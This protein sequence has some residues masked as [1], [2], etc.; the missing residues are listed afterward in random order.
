MTAFW[1]V[2]IVVQVSAFIQPSLQRRRPLMDQTS[3]CVSILKSSFLH[4]SFRFKDS[5]TT[6]KMSMLD[7][8]NDGVAAGLASNPIQPVRI[9]DLRNEPDIYFEVTQPSYRESP[10]KVKANG[11][12]HQSRLHQIKKVQRMSASPFGVYLKWDLA[13][14]PH[15]QLGQSERSDIR[16]RL[17]QSDIPLEIFEAD[18]SYIADGDIAIF[19]G[20]TPQFNKYASSAHQKIDFS[21]ILDK[22]LASTKRDGV[23]DRGNA[24]VSIGFA[25]LNQKNNCGKDVAVPQVIEATDRFYV[26]QMCHMSKLVDSLSDCLPS[27]PPIFKDDPIRCKEFAGSLPGRYGINDAALYNTLEAATFAVTCVDNGSSEQFTFGC[28]VDQ[29]NDRLDNWNVVACAFN[30]VRHQGKLYRV[31]VI[32]YS[33]S[34]IHHF[35]LRLSAADHLKRNL[36]EYFHH[37]KHRRQKL[38]AAHCLTTSGIRSL[39]GT[40]LLSIQAMLPVCGNCY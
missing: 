16:S 33:R 36:R 28:H 7:L 38:S 9:R 26:E 32:G 15:Y 21:G 3:R 35:Y 11:Y 29:L 8:P 37:D 24:S 22:V 27:K 12:L 30:Y 34:A 14:V 31:A 10:A 13:T 20:N 5:P 19:N 2:L 25:S 18:R 39:T 1:L 40:K 17:K 4:I 23:S 6:I